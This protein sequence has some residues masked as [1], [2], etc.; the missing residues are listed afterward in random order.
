M[1]FL[2]NIFGKLAG[3]FSEWLIVFVILVCLSW[4]VYHN[5]AMSER[6]AQYVKSLEDYKASVVDAQKAN[7][8]LTKVLATARQEN[9]L[10][11]EELQHEI[12][13]NQLYHTCVLPANG[14]RIIKRAR[15]SS[16]T[17]E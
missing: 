3:A 1:M 7:D 6:N 2:N 15:A 8:K 13:K 5:G 16:A 14:L 17:T 10:I 12:S 4:V 11:N 9:Q